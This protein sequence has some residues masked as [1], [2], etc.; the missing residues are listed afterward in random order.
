MSLH[1]LEADSYVVVDDQHLLL[2][3]KPKLRQ[4]K[5]LKQTPCFETLKYVDFIN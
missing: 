2:T 4:H 3:A 1:D 5:Q